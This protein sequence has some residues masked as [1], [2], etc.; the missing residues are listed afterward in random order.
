MEFRVNEKVYIDRSWPI[1][2]RFKN[3][4]A[5]NVK[6]YEVSNLKKK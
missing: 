3:I 1:E 6:C 4:F 5:I 2:I